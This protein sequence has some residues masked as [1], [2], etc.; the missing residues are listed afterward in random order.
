[1]KKEYFLDEIQISDQNIKV[2]YQPF[3][4]SFLCLDEEEDEIHLSILDKK[5]L[6]N[7]FDQQIKKINLKIKL[8]FLKKMLAIAGICS[9]TVLYKNQKNE[10][11]E[12]QNI[13]YVT[14][15]VEIDPLL[16]KYIDCIE[17]NPQFSKEQKRYLEKHFVNAF[18]KDYGLYLDEETNQKNLNLISKEQITYHNAKNLNGNMMILGTYSIPE[19]Q[20]D[21]YYPALE[22]DGTLLHEFTHSLIAIDNYSLEEGFCSAL[23]TKYGPTNRLTYPMENEYLLLIGEMIGKENLISCILNN[24]DE[25]LYEDM[26]NV[27]NTDVNTIQAILNEMD[28]CFSDYSHGNIY[29]ANKKFREIRQNL[30]ILA[31]QGN[32]DLA[33]NFI[34]YNAFINS[35]F[36][37]ATSFLEDSYFF[38]ANDRILF[39]N[40]EN[41]YQEDQQDFYQLTKKQTNN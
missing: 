38:T 6:R 33:H 16:E 11:T 21:I 26:A 27:T 1:M 31:I 18:I 29:A 35:D 12:D 20:I 34:I 9:L 10:I 3:K 15:L 24:D 8:N 39:I 41:K 2:Y 30:A 28:L 25:K 19:N 22:C 40:E 32:T 17:N 4:E 7:T 5:A 14:E 36:C 37:L 23:Q 13:E